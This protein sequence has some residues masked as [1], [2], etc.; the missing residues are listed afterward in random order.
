VPDH[1]TVSKNGTGILKLD[2]LRLRGPNGAKDEFYLAA[3]A[4][5]LKRLAKL[6]PNGPQIRAA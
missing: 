1:P 6:R 2:R 4:Q 3:A 5:N